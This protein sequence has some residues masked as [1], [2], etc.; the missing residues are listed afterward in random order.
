MY[1]VTSNLVLETK[2]AHHG[3]GG[4]STGTSLEKQRKSFVIKIMTSKPLP[5][6]ILHVIFAKAAPGKAFRGWGGGG[7]PNFLHV[8][9]KRNSLNQS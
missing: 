9:P 3:Q 8:F 4:G 5:L 2:R 6:K 1:R 7:Y